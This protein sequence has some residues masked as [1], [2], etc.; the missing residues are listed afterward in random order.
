MATKGMIFLEVGHPIIEENLNEKLAKGAKQEPCDITCSDFDGIKYKIFASADKK[1][2][3]EFSVGIPYM[4]SL[5]ATGAGAIVD[6]MYGDYKGG[7]APSGYDLTFNIDV[8]A[9]KEQPEV[10]AKNFAEIKRN[11]SAAPL[12][13]CFSALR[14]GRSGTLTPMVIPFRPSETMVLVPGADRINIFYTIDFSDEADR[15]IARVFLQEFSECQRKLPRAPGVN[16][17]YDCPSDLSK[18]K[19]FRD[20]GDHVGYI[21]FQVFKTHVEGAKMENAITLFQGFRQYLHYHIKASKS[22]L[23][24][25]MRKRVDLLLQV[26]KR[27]DPDTGDSGKKA[28]RTY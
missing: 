21:M 2:V 28:F 22:H 8:D 7:K 13:K 9:L 23:H 26:L 19:D 5:N 15:A 18:V 10:V 16:F 1:N 11:L 12:R 14:D 6:D 25:R 17:T 20:R 27:A 24:A 3:L 4:S